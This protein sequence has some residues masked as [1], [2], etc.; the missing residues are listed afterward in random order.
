MKIIDP[1]TRLF[2][3]GDRVG[4]PSGRQKIELDRNDLVYPL[5]E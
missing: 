5:E 3:T 4:T 1:P 2:E